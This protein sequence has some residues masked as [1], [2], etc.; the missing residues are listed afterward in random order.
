MIS[1]EDIESL[2][3]LARLKLKSGEAESLQKD[4]SNILGYVG[5]VSTFVATAAKNQ[6]N[7]VRNVMR[8]DEPRTDTDPLSGTEEAVRAQFPRREGDYNVV[9]KII[10]KDE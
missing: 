10:Q 8:L 5:Q 2:A 6:E 9:K 1:K 3:T 4:I 7:A